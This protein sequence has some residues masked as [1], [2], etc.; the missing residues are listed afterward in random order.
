MNGFTGRVVQYTRTVR[1]VLG[2][3]FF[4]TT[5]TTRTIR[6]GRETMAH[7]SYGW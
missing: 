1:L 4:R 3:V 6:T 5:R 7:E 2:D